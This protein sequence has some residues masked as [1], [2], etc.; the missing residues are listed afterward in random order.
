MAGEIIRALMGRRVT[1]C[2]AALAISAAAVID[3]PASCR[4]DAPSGSAPWDGMPGIPHDSCAGMPCQT[5]GD[6]HE[7]PLFAGP[8]FA[9]ERMVVVVC[10]K[11]ESAEAPV[12][13][14]PPPNASV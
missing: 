6:H 10:P 2:L 7:A 9:L 3:N 8:V 14:T 5:P 1:A 13:P 11:P 12:P 4:E